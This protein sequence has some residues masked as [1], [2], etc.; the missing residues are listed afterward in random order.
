MREF[1]TNEGHA[2]LAFQLL[3][4][5]VTKS[6]AIIPKVIIGIVQ[7]Y[8]ENKRML[9]VQLNSHFFDQL[10]HIFIIW[11]LIGRSVLLRNANFDHPNELSYR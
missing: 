7:S 10:L 8:F 4:Q 9:F 6:Y 2:L 11:Y 5:N 3:E 1:M